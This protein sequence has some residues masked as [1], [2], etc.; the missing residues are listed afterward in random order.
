MPDITYNSIQSG[1]ASGFGVLVQ[2]IPRTD[3]QDLAADAGGQYRYLI[4]IIQTAHPLKITSLVLYRSK[5]L[6][7]SFPAPYTGH[8]ADINVGRATNLYLLWTAQAN[9]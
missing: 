8:S 1:A 7:D 6:V 3:L 5:S 9:Y 2:N 4:P